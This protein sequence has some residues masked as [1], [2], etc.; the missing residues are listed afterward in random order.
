MKNLHAMLAA[1]AVAVIL[2]GCS[3]FSGP[4]SPGALSA[5]LSARMDQPNATLNSQEAI[6]LVNAY[7]ATRNMPPLVADA[8]LNGTAQALANQYAQTGTAPTK[9]Q[10]LAQMKLSAGYATFAETFSGWRNN[11]ADAVGLAAPATKAGIAV[12]YNPTSSY[13][14]HW[15]LVLGN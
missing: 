6:G 12:A 4:A 2:A 7:R 14:V 11:A 15:V 3:S 1:G 5:G 8:G 10:A 13:G 9:P